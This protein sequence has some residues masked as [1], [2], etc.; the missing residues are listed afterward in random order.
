MYLSNLLSGLSFKKHNSCSWI[1]SDSA[2]ALL[3]AK[4]WRY[5]LCTKPIALRFNLLDELVKIG[6]MTVTHKSTKFRPTDIFSKYLGIVVF[7][8][9][10]AQIDEYR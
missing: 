3:L 6:I 1:N 2:G 7:R 5:S 9:T 8:N 10:M 4:N